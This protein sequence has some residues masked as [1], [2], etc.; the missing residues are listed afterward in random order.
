M[1][2][3]NSTFVL[4]TSKNVNRVIVI[5]LKISFELNVESF[6]NG[7]EMWGN[8][9]HFTATGKDCCSIGDRVPALFTN[10][11]NYL[12]LCTNIDDDGDKCWTTEVGKIKTHTW[13]LVEYEQ[14]FVAY[15]W[16]FTVKINGL[17]G[18]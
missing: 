3:I 11:G 12:Y 18:N 13:Y 16:R 14:K 17:D 8:V 5:N 9:F 6:A 10:S 15:Q 4:K 7:G 2:R 1:G